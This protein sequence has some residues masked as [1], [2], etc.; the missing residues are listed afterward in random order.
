VKHPPTKANGPLAMSAL[1]SITKNGEVTKMRFGPIGKPG[2][3]A[4][5]KTL[6]R[7]THSKKCRLAAE[8]WPVGLPHVGVVFYDYASE[9][10]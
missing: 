10:D 4:S 6:G 3:R 2:A 7:K 9:L 5:E 1:F 8:N